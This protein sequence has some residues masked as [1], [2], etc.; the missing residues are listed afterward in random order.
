MKNKEVPG[1]SGQGGSGRSPPSADRRAYALSL[2][3]L[4]EL[5]RQPEP[6]SQTYPSGSPQLYF[7]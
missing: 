7:R 5:S 4:L 3:V 1:H 2:L 6:P